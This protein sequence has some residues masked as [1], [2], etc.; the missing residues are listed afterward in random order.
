[1]IYLYDILRLFLLS[2]LI[3]VPSIS[4]GLRR[5]I[6]MM[7]YTYNVCHGQAGVFN[8]NQPT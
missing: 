8:F 7:I 4:L 5:G 2:E 3:G 1:M 6:M